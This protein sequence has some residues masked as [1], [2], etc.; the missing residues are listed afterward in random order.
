MPTPENGYTQAETGGDGNSRDYMCMGNETRGWAR[1]AMQGGGTPWAGARGG[2]SCMGGGRAR[3]G[4]DAG[5]GMGGNVRTG[6]CISGGSALGTARLAAA[7]ARALAAADHA[8][9]F[10]RLPDCFLAPYGSSLAAH[11]QLGSLICCTVSVLL[12]L[13]FPQFLLS[14][15]TPIRMAISG[16]ER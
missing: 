2:G 6:S 13:P 5:V 8:L 3:G 16:Q 7:R 4:S 14:R 10:A 11:L 1:G 9:G 12:T 15:F